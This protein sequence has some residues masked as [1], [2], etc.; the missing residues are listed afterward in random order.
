MKL[1]L[2]ELEYVVLGH[3]KQFEALMKYCTCTVDKLVEMEFHEKVSWSVLISE[4]E[5]F[6]GRKTSTRANI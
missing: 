4:S 2:T 6:G 3:T 5:I 1:H